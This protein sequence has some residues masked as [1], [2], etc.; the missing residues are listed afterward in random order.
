MQTL[1]GKVFNF[2]GARINQYQAVDREGTS[3]M[4]AGYYAI[5]K[6]DGKDFIELYFNPEPAD[7]GSRGM[8]D[9]KEVKFNE[10]EREDSVLGLLFVVPPGKTIVAVQSQG[11]RVD[12]GTEFS[13]GQ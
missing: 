10:L 12:F 11:G 1:F 8:V 13:V 5:V 3:Y 6:R 9:L 2:V 7:T 4:L